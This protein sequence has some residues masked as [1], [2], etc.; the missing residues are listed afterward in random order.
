MYTH[1]LLVIF[2]VDLDEEESLSLDEF[3]A[4]I[5]ILLGNIATRVL[6]QLGFQLLLVPFLSAYIMSCCAT[7]YPI[8]DVI[9]P[10]VPPAILSSLIIA[11]VVPAVLQHV[12]IFFSKT[13]QNLENESSPLLRKKSD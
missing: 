6:F 1:C 10:S 9:P 8:P 13:E 2:Q 7:Y 12:D 11:I 3:Q 4:V 5:S